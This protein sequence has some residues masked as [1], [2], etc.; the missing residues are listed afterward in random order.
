MIFDFA[1][2]NFLKP[3]AFHAAYFTRGFSDVDGTKQRNV[4]PG[5]GLN[6]TGLFRRHAY[7]KAATLLK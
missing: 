2:N 1:R 7:K 6:L 4:F 3:T 5:I